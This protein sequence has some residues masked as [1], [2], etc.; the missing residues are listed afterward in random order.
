MPT[1]Y[2][3]L[4]AAWVVIVRYAVLTECHRRQQCRAPDLL[5]TPAR[6]Q[7]V[8]C[9]FGGIE[10]LRGMCVPKVVVRDRAPW[11]MKTEIPPPLQYPV[12]PFGFKFV[13]S[14]CMMFYSPSI[15][16]RI[17]GLAM[18]AGCFLPQR[19]ARKSA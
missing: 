14:L 3:C 13:H 15:G 17:K 12:A 2:E 7:A 5:R 19:Q 10:G 4:Y 9:R 1:Q 8:P 11:L 18:I 16:M 6:E